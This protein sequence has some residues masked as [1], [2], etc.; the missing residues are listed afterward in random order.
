MEVNRLDVMGA[1]R[2][3]TTGYIYIYKYEYSEV[4]DAIG[5]K[6][7]QAGLHSQ[8]AK[9]P[10]SQAAKQPSNECSWHGRWDE[11]GPSFAVHLEAN[12]RQ[13]DVCTWYIQLVNLE[14]LLIKR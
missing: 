2:T 11:S 3:V 1:E 5:R 14:N 13:Q 12:K 6:L 9:Q 10:S 7:G 4:Q 8:A